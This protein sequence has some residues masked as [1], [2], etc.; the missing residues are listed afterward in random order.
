MTALSQ[1]KQ[2][3]E[4]IERR[5]KKLIHLPEERAA[6]SWHKASFSHQR[7]NKAAMKRTHPLT[8]KTAGTKNV[9]FRFSPRNT[10]EANKSALK[11]LC[12]FGG[13]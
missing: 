5:R 10:T 6:S 2:Q 8:A 9:T 4:K 12:L 3:A 11:S 13:H 7:G 1:L